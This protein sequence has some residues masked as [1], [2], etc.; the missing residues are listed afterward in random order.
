[1]TLMVPSV[2]REIWMARS[3]RGRDNSGKGDVTADGIDINLPGFNDIVF[4]HF[5]VDPGGNRGIIHYTTNRV[6]AGFLRAGAS[7]KE[8]QQDNN[9]KQMLFHDPY[10]FYV[11][12]FV[13]EKHAKIIQIYASQ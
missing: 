1:M 7:G 6:F 3:F 9:K 4:E 13:P 11:I 12:K 5:M 2:L 8:K 10:P